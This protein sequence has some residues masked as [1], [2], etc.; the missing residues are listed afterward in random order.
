VSR[1]RLLTLLAPAAAVV[2]SWFASGVRTFT[3]PAEFLTFIPGA[4]V[5]LV[6]LLP[7]SRLPK[8][9]VARSRYRRWSVLPWLALVAAIVGLELLQLFAKPRST[10]PTLSSM[11]NTLLST[12]PS[13][14]LGYLGFLV[15]G[16]LLI[17]DL[18]GPRESR[19]ESS[20]QS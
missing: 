18:V 6:T 17:R 13:R 15:L 3:R 5:L 8:A 4:V 1:R 11:L 20:G 19:R 16:W 7:S 10:H 14:F 12:H 2:W 9:G